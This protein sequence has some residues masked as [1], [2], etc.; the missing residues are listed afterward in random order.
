MGE[1]EKKTHSCET[2]LSNLVISFLFL[3]FLSLTLCHVILVGNILVERCSTLD[4]QASKQ[5]AQPLP[6]LRGN[7][8]IRQFFVFYFLILIRK[9]VCIAIVFHCIALHC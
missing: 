4:V 8:C 5:A 2:V 1:K 6:V 3:F 7:T 9:K